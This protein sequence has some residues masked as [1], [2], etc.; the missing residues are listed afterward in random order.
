MNPEEEVKG[1]IAIQTMH[2]KCEHIKE[3]L[4]KANAIAGNLAGIQ[5]GVDHDLKEASGRL[6]SLANELR[7]IQD[8]SESLLDY[9]L[10][11]DDLI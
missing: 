7:I 2:E 6:E 9:L 8:S 5:P 1:T 11:M 10:Q 3:V 4:V